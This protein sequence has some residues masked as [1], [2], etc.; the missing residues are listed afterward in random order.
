MSNAVPGVPELPLTSR[1]RPDAELTRGAVTAGADADHVGAVASNMVSSAITHT[2]AA[3]GK[4]GRR[5]AA[6]AFGRG[7]DPDEVMG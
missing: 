6:S 1:H 7:D 2:A 5:A 4:R 3:A